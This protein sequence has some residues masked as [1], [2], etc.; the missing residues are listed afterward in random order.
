M[1]RETAPGQPVLPVV[2]GP[3]QPLARLLVGERGRVIGPGQGAEVDLAFL[4]PGPGHGPAALE[5]EPH[6]GGQGQRDPGGPAGR[7]ADALGVPP[8]AVGPGPLVA[9]VVEDRLA[10]ERDLDLAGDAADGA[11]QH[12]VGV[13]VGGRPA[14]GVGQLALVVP[15]P[16]HQRVAHHQPPGRGGPAGLQHHRP[17][18]VPAGGRDVD[19]FRAEAEPA[20]RPVQDRA[21]HARR[22]HPGQ[23]H[24]L[25]V[26]A[27]R[28]QGGGLAVGQEAVLTDRRER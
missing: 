17:G 21:E 20:G 5:P 22:V 14:V 25:H 8:V 26:P 12:M 18:Q 28:D 27:R 10:L 23:A 3:Q 24:P 4:H 16:H 11:Q 2:R 19:P 7:A 6:V 13:V 9:A 1:V 15:G